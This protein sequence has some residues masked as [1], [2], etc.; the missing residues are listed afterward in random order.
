[1][2]KIG[3]TFALMLILMVATSSVALLTA[4]SAGAQTSS[5][6][7]MSNPVILSPSTPPPTP[8]FAPTPVVTPT[9][10][11]AIEY[12][13]A[14]RTTEGANT[15]LSL[16]V[17]VKYN[18]G[19]ASIF[20]FQ[21]F[22]LN[23]FTDISHGIPPTLMHEHS[24]DVRPTETGSITVGSTNKKADFQLIFIFPTIQTTFYQEKLHFTSYELTY[25]GS[26]PISSLPPQ[27]PIT[28]NPTSA[29]AD[30]SVNLLLLTIMGI[31]AVIIALV[32]VSVLYLRRHR[33]TANLK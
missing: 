30:L 24:R 18:F 33:K 10:S 27:T 26:L 19:N 16:S 22:V 3:R 32:A 5:I 12:D 29:N 20:S 17:S 6:Q 1:M 15:I 23:V 8:T 9:R 31:V 7:L 25:T 14:G 21:D 13:E 2:E 11:I 28:P 4:K